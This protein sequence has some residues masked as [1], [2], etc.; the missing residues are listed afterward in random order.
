M[1]VSAYSCYYHFHSRNRTRTDDSLSPILFPYDP[2]STSDIPTQPSTAKN[3]RKEP[4][5]NAP[6]IKASDL[7]PPATKLELVLGAE[8]DIKD[9]D[10]MMREIQALVEREADGSGDL[11]GEL[12]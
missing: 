7:I 8:G 2:S 6:A 9:A 4:T 5:P 12:G 11:A 10:R 3:P 1:S